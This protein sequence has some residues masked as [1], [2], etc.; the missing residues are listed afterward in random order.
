MWQWRRHMNV[1]RFVAE[2]EG[3]GELPE[4]ASAVFV[5]GEMTVTVV[6]VIG[7]DRVEI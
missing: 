3:V 2:T 6:M 1:F 5:D 4:L 7:D